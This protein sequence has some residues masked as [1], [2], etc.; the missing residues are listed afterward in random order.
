MFLSVNSVFKHMF[1]TLWKLFSFLYL[2]NYHVPY[3]V[4]STLKNHQYVFYDFYILVV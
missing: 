1:A 4:L 2:I 3:I